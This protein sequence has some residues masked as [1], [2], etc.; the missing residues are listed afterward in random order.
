MANDIIKLNYTQARAMA[1]SMK[2]GSKQ[3]E[4][5]INE[6]NKIMSL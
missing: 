6:M 5:S 3:L 2:K 1:A 4:A